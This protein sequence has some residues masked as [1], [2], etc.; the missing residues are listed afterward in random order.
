MRVKLAVL[1]EFLCRL[2]MFAVISFT[3]R[4]AFQD[5]LQGRREG[6]C[7]GI[8]GRPD[9]AYLPTCCS[10]RSYASRCIDRTILV[11]VVCHFNG[12]LFGTWELTV[13][14]LQVAILRRLVAR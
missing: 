14:F 1:E 12:K 13:P 7:M 2:P 4:L 6:C 3:L 10:A 11:V 5:S 9:A 8:E